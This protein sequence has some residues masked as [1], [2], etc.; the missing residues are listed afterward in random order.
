MKNKIVI[1]EK[2]YRDA[3]N[4]LFTE[5]DKI[6][7]KNSVNKIIS[8]GNISPLFQDS[9]NYSLCPSNVQQSIYPIGIYNNY[10]LYVDPHQLWSDNRIILKFNDEIILEVEIVDD[11][12]ILI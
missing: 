4:Q 6:L 11:N 8:N 7:L 1:N 3:I 12:Y 2:H 5:F 9:I 10:E